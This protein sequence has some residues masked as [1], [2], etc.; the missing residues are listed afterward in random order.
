MHFGNPTPQ[1]ADTT[2]APMAAPARW[3][4]GARPSCCRSATRYIVRF[5]KEQF[6]DADWR[7]DDDAVVCGAR[8]LGLAELSATARERDPNLRKWDEHGTPRS[9]AFNVQG[10]RIAVNPR[11]FE[12]NYQECTRGGCRRVINPMQCRGQIEGGSRQSLGA[13]LYRKNCSLMAPGVRSIQ[14]SATICS[15]I[16]RRPAYG[17]LFF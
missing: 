9:I 12:I 14:P 4:P 1:T 13:S 8:R 17:S 15:G 10:F 11:T 3:W 7:L 16:C 6:G 5:A 2:Q